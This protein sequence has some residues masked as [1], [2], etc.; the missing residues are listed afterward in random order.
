MGARAYLAALGRFLT[1]D[2]I[3]GGNTTTY[4][5]PNDPINAFDL[6][7]LFAWR[8]VIR[9]AVTALGVAAAGACIVASAGICEGVLAASIVTSTASDAWALANN[10][11]QMTRGRFVENL[12]FNLVTAFIRGVRAARTEV[13]AARSF[14][15]QLTRAVGGFGTFPPLGQDRHEA[16][17]LPGRS[18]R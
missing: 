7:G 2:P 12:E 11:E 8:N 13:G 1:P 6:T 14:A 18:V 4:N 9:G 10:T 16:S 3:P 17:E 5:Y 15:D